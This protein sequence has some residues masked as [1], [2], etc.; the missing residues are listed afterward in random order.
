MSTNYNKPDTNTEVSTQAVEIEE[1]VVQ[2]SVKKKPLPRKIFES[3][4]NP[5]GMSE[6][7]TTVKQ[8]AINQA[9]DAFKNIL[10][11]AMTGAVSAVIYGDKKPMNNSYTQYGNSRQS[12]G[13]NNNRPYHRPSSSSARYVQSNRIDFDSTTFNFESFGD[14]QQVMDRMDALM[15]R[16]QKVHISDFLAAVGQQSEGAHFTYGWRKLSSMGVSSNEDGYYII[17]PEPERL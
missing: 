15:G 1:V 8:A 14:A 6:V 2:A 3:V 17:L 11:S 5:D 10:Y 7:R 4:F 13:G 12:F 16:Y 9:T